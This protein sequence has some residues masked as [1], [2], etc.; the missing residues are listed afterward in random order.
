MPLDTTYSRGVPVGPQE[1][2]GVRPNLPNAERRGAFAVYAHPNKWAFEDGEWLPVITTQ[3]AKAGLHGTISQGE[4]LDDTA[5]RAT[6][7][8]NGY[9]DLTYHPTLLAKY[10]RLVNRHAMQDGGAHYTPPWQG[11]GIVGNRT[12]IRTDEEMYRAF[13]RDVIDIIGPMS[14]EVFEDRTAILEGR[15]S[16][17]R[18]DRSGG[19]NIMRRIDE[20]TALLAAQKGAWEK[21]FG[22]PKK[23]TRK[24]E[25]EVADV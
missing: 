21:Q 4:H 10:G 14:I 12:R 20:A 6:A 24:S 16:S 8:R 23:A 7:A 2:A 19:A 17:M 11:V 1:A 5:A 22:A 13:R 25:P 15:I 18:L 9:V 3:S